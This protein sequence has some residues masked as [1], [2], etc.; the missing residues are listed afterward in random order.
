MIL[1][2]ADTAPIHY[3]V[4]IDAAG[5]LPR[6]YDRVVLPKTLLQELLHAHAPAVV[7]NWSARLP[8]WIEV[9]ECPPIQLQAA[10][11]PG[12]VEG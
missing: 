4:I 2:V 3:L 7:R 8:A 10:L 1:V 12:E 9:R 6:L 11:D 5:V